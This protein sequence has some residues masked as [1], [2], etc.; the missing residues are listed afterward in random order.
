M[1]FTREDALKRHLGAKSAARC[2]ESG[3]G[4]RRDE[5]LGTEAAREAQRAG[6]PDRV[7]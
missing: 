4:A 6:K 3:M 2:G 7:V 1:R 5:F